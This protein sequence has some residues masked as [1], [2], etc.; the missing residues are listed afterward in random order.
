M[1]LSGADLPVTPD[2]FERAARNAARLL[3]TTVEA[4]AEDA[5]VIDT[6]QVKVTAESAGA[7]DLVRASLML[8]NLMEMRHETGGRLGNRFW[9]NAQLTYQRALRNFTQAAGLRGD[10]SA[11]ATLRATMQVEINAFIAA[12]TALANEDR[13]LTIA[14][15]AE[16]AAVSLADV[17][18]PSA[19]PARSMLPPPR[20][21][22][23]PHP[24]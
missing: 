9:K 12:G 16:R 22:P 21:P 19:A 3:G 23:P 10:K 5:D 18:V 15:T 2:L 7:V 17:E 4:L 1:L 14:A 11:L 24:E 13:P 20:R 8:R 6:E